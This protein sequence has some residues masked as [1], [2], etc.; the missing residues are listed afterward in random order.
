MD[1]SLERITHQ[2][3]RIADSLSDTDVMQIS[4]QDAL[5]AWGLRMYE[6]EFLTA[7]ERL[8]IEVVD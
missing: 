4:E 8:G 5:A 6:A 2:L 7:L 1:E 3:T